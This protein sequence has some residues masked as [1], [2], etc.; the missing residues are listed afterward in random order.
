MNV[1]GR[2]LYNPRLAAVIFLH[3]PIGINYISF[4]TERGLVTGMDY[5]WGVAALIVVIAL[6]VVLPV[7]LFKDRRTPFAFSS[8]EV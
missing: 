3:V 7:Q 8:E 2:T 4:V 5:V 6:I 1:K